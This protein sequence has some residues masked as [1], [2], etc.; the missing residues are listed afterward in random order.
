V[1]G[2]APLSLLI[3][4]RNPESIG[5]RPDGD[6]AAPGTRNPE[7][8]TQNLEPAGYSLSDAL[9]TPAFWVFAVGASL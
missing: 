2:L 1:L 9:R 6:D 5:L 7:P 4:R 3:V 8:G